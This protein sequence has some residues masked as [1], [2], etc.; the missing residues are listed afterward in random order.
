MYRKRSLSD[1]NRYID[2]PCTLRA[3]SRRF[4]VVPGDDEGPEEGRLRAEGVPRGITWVSALIVIVLLVL[5]AIA[6]VALIA[7]FA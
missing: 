6:V 2:E 7:F 4:D 1:R 3:V 5:L